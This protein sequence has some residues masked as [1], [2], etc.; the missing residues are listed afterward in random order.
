M[1]HIDARA[2]SFPRCQTRT[3][4]LVSL[5]KA[6]VCCP[7]T[8]PS[9]GQFFSGILIRAVEKCR[10]AEAVCRRTDCLHS[11]PSR[12]RNDGGG[13][14]PQDGRLRAD[15]RAMVSANGGYIAPVASIDRHKVT[16]SALCDAYPNRSYQSHNV[17]W[18]MQT[19][20]EPGSGL[21]LIFC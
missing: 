3:G 14:L 4:R 16:I 21:S 15:D 10:E 2:G 8:G 12:R 20:P 6:L 5:G 13:D 19:G 18:R 9:G 17:F 7:L 11:M 1:P